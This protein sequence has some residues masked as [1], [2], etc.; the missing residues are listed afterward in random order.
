[1][2]VAKKISVKKTIC[3]AIICLNPLFARL[4]R[5]N[6]PEVKNPLS[7]GSTACESRVDDLGEVDAEEGYPHKRL[8]LILIY[9]CDIFQASW[10]AFAKE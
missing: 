2:G 8:L 4:K 5:R 7:F 10:S 3:L 9:P 1:M 6:I